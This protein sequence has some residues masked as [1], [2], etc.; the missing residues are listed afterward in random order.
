ML[1]GRIY[2]GARAGANLLKHPPYRIRKLMDEEQTRFSDSHKRPPNMCST[3]VF[4]MEP[5]V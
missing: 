5:H 3:H 1:E 2:V 4:I